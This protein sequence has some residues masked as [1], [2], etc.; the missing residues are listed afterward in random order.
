MIELRECARL[1]ARIT[2][3]ACEINRK[4]GR[5]LSCEG[6][7]GLG[8]SSFMSEEDLVSKKKCSVK[9]CTTDAHARGMCWKHER[10]EL[11]VEPRSGKPLSHDKVVAEAVKAVENT[12]TIPPAPKPQ[13]NPAEV[14]L[15]DMGLEIRALFEAK[16]QE[17]LGDLQHATGIR[18]TAQRFLAMCDALDGLGY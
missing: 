8:V 18:Q 15:C 16:C 6:C 11:G 17:W 1:N 5:V 9:G 12:A 3:R 14:V 2:E 13:S 7:P 10:S 4:S